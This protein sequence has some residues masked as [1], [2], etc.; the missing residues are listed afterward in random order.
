MLS[1]LYVHEHVCVSVRMV[2]VITALEHLL[3]NIARVSPIGEPV[4]D[5]RLPFWRNLCDDRQGLLW[6]TFKIETVNFR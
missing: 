5:T 2:I 1:M 4:W 3:M 6:R